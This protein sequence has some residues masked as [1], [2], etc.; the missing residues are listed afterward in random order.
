ALQVTGTADTPVCISGPP[1]VPYNIFKDGGVTQ[2]ALD[3]LYL[4]GSAY[5]TETQRIVHIDF[6]GDLGK[7]NRHSPLASDGNSVNLGHEARKE[8]VAFDP[9]SGESGGLLAG[10]G[11]AAAPIHAGY[12]VNEGFFE[13]G[14]PIV[15]DKPAITSLTASVGYRYSDYTTSGTVSTGKFAVQYEPISKL[16]LRA[17]FQRAI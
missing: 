10:F 14:G 16:R 5:G 1:C 6:T 8:Q 12:G 13:M 9:D 11:G 4:N 7:Y 17:S 2:A 3:Y 15:Q